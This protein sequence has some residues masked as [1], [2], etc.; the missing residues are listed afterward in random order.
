MNIL[1]ISRNSPFESIGGIERYITNLITFYKAQN[2]STLFLLLP[3]EGEDYVKKDG[4]VTIFFTNSLFISRSKTT[5]NQEITQKAQ[6]F[7][8]HVNKI[9]I[10]CDITVVCAENFHTDLP[11][12]YSLLLTMQT[13]MKKI[14]L[15]LQI[16]SF[17]TTQLQTELVNQL[18]WDRISCVSKSVS[19]DCFQKGA[20]IQSL[21]THYLG[22]DT[23][24]FNIIHEK[25]QSVR[26][27][28]D[29]L[30]SD[31]LVL[32][33]TRI[34][35]GAKDILHEKGL[36]N[37]IQAFSKLAP[38]FPDLKLLIAI[39]TPPE[40]LIN[41]FNAAFEMLQGYIMLHGI[42][43]QTILKTFSL[44]EMP[45]VYNEANIFCL[46]SQNETFGQVF[47][48]AMSCGLPVIGTKVGGIPEIISDSYNGF[49]VPPDDPS[50]LAQKM[51]QLL[52]NDEI[53]Q[54]FIHAGV[55][56]VKEKFTAEMQFGLFDAMLGE[57]VSKAL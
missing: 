20:N 4:N 50:I 2:V 54:K 15:V 31:M 19:G 17:A 57:M 40:N 21:A 28:L 35:R 23:N 49:L 16:H 14:P 51:E 52:T 6:L 24:E 33:A 41:Q 18:P 56:V 26:K 46:P 43:S 8:E 37:L 11:A 36:I 38:R 44:H 7:A 42:E 5:T 30:D 22:V 32:T 12:A 55:K 47:I 9:I 13:S 1:F 48:E 27:E 34:I 29:I 53:R 3:T 10:A 25:E 45:A 39:G